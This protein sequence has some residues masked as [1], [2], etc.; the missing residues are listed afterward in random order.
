VEG[1]SSDELGRVARA[2]GLGIALGFF[3]VLIARRA[4]R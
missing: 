3:L 4:S 1:P 2:I